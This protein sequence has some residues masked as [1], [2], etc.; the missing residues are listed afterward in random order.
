M[1]EDLV[2]ATGEEAFIPKTD[3]DASGLFLVTQYEADRYSLE[4]GLRTEQTDIDPVGN[5]CDFS[6]TSLS[7]SG[8]LLYH[9]N[10]DTIFLLGLSR[11]ERAPSVEE[12]FSNIN[13]VTCPRP[14]DDDDLVFHAATNLLEVGNPDLR[15]EVATNIELGW[16][17]HSGR[18]RSEISFY[19]NEISDYIYLDVA[20]EVDE[21]SI[22]IYDGR[23]AEFTGLEARVDFSVVERENLS[24]ELSV[25]GDTVRAEFEKGGNIPRIAPGKFGTR[26]AVLGN[27]WSVHLG[28]TRVLEQDRPDELELSTNGYTRLSFYGDYHWQV[29]N[30]GQFKVFVQGSNLM[31]EEIRNHASLLRNFAPEAGRNIRV[32]LR[33][34]Y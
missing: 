2:D 15:N 1:G 33:Y 3:I 17:R 11:S 16:R 8:S 12:L 5:G 10:D 18:I 21:Q 31:D 20:G 23:D 4:L 29:S 9:I 34:S 7:A 19:H 24:V 32:G 28:L 27:Q 22:A 13:G 6:D 25:F 14:A 30:T 26:L